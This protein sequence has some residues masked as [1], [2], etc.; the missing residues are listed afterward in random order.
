MLNTVKFLQSRPF[1]TALKDLK[2]QYHIDSRIYRD[3]V[4]LSYDKTRYTGLEDEPTEV[5]RAAGFH[6]IIKECRSLVL[7]ISPDWH[8]VSR[9]FDRFRNRVES[10]TQYGL[11]PM[12]AYEKLDGSVVTLFRYGDNWLYRTN[13]VV[14]PSGTCNSWGTK[15]SELIEPALGTGFLKSKMLDSMHNDSFI[16]E[17]T[18]PDNKIV[19]QYNETKMSLLA[20]RHVDGRYSSR[21][22]CDHVAKECDWGRPKYYPIHSI[23]HGIDYVNGLTDLQEGLVVYN[24][25]NEPAYKEKS[26]DYLHAHKTK[27]EELTPKRVWN[28]VMEDNAAEYLSYFPEDNDRIEPYIKAYDMLIED[29]ECTV[30]LIKGDH[31]VHEPSLPNYNKCLKDITDASI[32]CERDIY[33]IVKNHPGVKVIQRAL[34]SGNVQ[35]QF[36][37]LTGPAKIKLLESYL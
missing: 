21:T 25:S 20:I 4:C 11:F 22:C 5:Q 13:G 6:P 16:F 27:G 26:E 23:Q 12:D 7:Q 2:E 15:W 34:K 18:S 24:R 37:V 8:V 32:E 35:S 36:E 14:M 33:E 9:A 19:T 3:L 28:M 30:S 10:D 1:K 31:D 29:L 17:L